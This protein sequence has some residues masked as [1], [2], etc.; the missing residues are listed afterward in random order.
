MGLFVGR[1][2]NVKGA[3]HRCLRYTN[4]RDGIIAMLLKSSTECK[5]LGVSQ[6]KSLTR[7]CTL[8]P[9]EPIIISVEHLKL[10]CGFTPPLMHIVQEMC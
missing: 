1:C 4:S 3:K 10:F 6:K 2:L 9:Q 5:N 8:D 7:R